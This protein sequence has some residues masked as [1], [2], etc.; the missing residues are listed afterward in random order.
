MLA[1]DPT[2][3]IAPS[4]VIGAD[5]EAK[6]GQSKLVLKATNQ[7]GTSRDRVIPFKVKAKAFRKES[8][9]VS[10]ATGIAL[11]ALTTAQNG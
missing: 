2:A 9:N 1:I 5:V 7:A 4:A 3:R 11:Y 6:P 10:I 8:F